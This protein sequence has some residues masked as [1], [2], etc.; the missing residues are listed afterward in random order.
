MY[1]Y[2]KVPLIIIK[3]FNKGYITSR[4]K[5]AMLAQLCML[6]SNDAIHFTINIDNRNILFTCDELVE[7][8]KPVYFEYVARLSV[9]TPQGDPDFTVY[10]TSDSDKFYIDDQL[11]IKEDY[12]EN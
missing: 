10:Y 3:Y 6:S 2:E 11:N 5:T 9:Y 1:F 8:L 7:P 12:N 4:E